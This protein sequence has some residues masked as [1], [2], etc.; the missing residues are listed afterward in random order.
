V[1]EV[2][3]SPWVKTPGQTDVVIKDPFRVYDKK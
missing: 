2:L 3:K 1:D